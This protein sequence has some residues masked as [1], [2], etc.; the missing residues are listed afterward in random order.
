MTATCMV[1][2]TCFWLSPASERRAGAVLACAAWRAR[3]R[4]SKSPSLWRLRSHGHWWPTS[5][6]RPATGRAAR[7]S[8]PSSTSSRATTRPASGTSSLAATGVR[9]RT[10]TCGCSATRQRTS[11]SALTRRA[12]PT[13]R[14][15]P[16][17][18]RRGQASTH[19]F[20]PAP[21]PAPTR[22][23]WCA[24]SFMRSA[25][26]SRASV[27][28]LPSRVTSRAST[29]TARSPMWTRTT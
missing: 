4:A 6:W 8:S 15:S 22:A 9:Q 18:R 23:T 20:T 2:I 25:A 27:R 5:C 29:R 26:T 12:C 19:P 10:S 28:A 16:A 3:A 17:A 1:V 24:P 21:T 11:A 13:R 7:A 14:G